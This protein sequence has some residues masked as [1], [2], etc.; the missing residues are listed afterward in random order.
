MNDILLVSDDK[1]KEYSSLNDNVFPKNIFP[2]I[3]TSQ[4]IELQQTIGSCLYD[5]ICSMVDEGSISNPEN[6]NYKY[7]LDK[8]IQPFLIYTTLSHLTIETSTKLT[9]FGTVMSNDEHIVNVDLKERDMIRKQ[10]EYYSDSYRKNMQRYLKANR[11]LF[12]ELDCGCGCN[13]E[14]K[15]N[16]DSSAS[17]QLFLGGA[18]GYK[19]IK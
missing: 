12:P 14:I 13:G 10:Y 1:I 5:A 8:H 4:D 11:D 9:N 3:R 18:R 19:S 17:S 7:L 15:P 2:S 6:S 16:L